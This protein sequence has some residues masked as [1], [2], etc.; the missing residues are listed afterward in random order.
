M[1]NLSICPSL[2]ISQSIVEEMEEMEDLHHLQTAQRTSE[3]VNDSDVLKIR[4]DDGTD[5][6]RKE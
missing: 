6:K 3:R 5:A 4:L 2:I 1:E